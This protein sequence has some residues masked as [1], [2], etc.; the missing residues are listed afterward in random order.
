M[1]KGTPFPQITKDAVINLYQSGYDV[2]KIVAETKLPN[3][4]VYLWLQKHRI[5]LRTTPSWSKFRKAAMARNMYAYKL[6]VL[7]VEV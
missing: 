7:G 6:Q 1:A 4:T 5:M 3:S 2:S